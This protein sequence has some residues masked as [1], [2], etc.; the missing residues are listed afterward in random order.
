MHE[1]EVNEL[2]IFKLD[3]L[4]YYF[5]SC[6]DINLKGAR[7]IL[8]KSGNFFSEKKL[9]LEILET[10]FLTCFRHQTN[11]TVVLLSCGSSFR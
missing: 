3:N 4:L 8:C 2:H 6:Q 11:I 10:K 1:T 9:P 5:Q 7:T